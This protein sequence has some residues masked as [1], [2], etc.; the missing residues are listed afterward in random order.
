MPTFARE[1]ELLRIADG[2]VRHLRTAARMNGDPMAGWLF[3]QHLLDAADDILEAA[4]L[5]FELKQVLED[6]R[7][8]RAKW[9][10]GLVTETKE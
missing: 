3:E 1:N 10:A 8:N 4:E 2:A 6:L 5:A 7:E 9:V